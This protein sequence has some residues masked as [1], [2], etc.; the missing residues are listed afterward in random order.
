MT[1][2]M[3]AI[4]R[5]VGDHGHVADHRKHIPKAAFFCKRA[6]AD[7]M[8]QKS[9]YGRLGLLS[10]LGSACVV[11]VFV[12]LFVCSM[13]PSTTQNTSHK[14]EPLLHTLKTNP[15][16][17]RSGCL[18]SPRLESSLPPRARGV[19]RSKARARLH[20]HALRRLSLCV[21][22]CFFCC[23]SLSRGLSRDDRHNMVV[24]WTRGPRDAGFD[25]LPGELP[26]C[27]DP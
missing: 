5:N 6:F 10:C 16:K 4:L 12:G 19:L 18:G 27:P 1:T 15:V 13:D 17:R 21:F 23:L 7:N 25:W 3:F 26:C 8:L 11:F 9:F 22:V 20:G 14:R 2:R 24:A